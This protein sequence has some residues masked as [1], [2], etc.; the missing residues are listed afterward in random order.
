MGQSQERLA[1]EA[2][3]LIAKLYEVER[4]VAELDAFERL[5]IRQAKA[6]PLASALH[7]W[8]TTQRQKVPPGS[9]IAKAIDYSLG[10]WQPLTRCIADGDLPIEN[11]WVENQIRRDRAGPQELAVRRVTS[12][13]QARGRRDEPGA[14]GP[15]ERARPARLSEG[16]DGTPADASRKPHRRAAAA[17]L[18]ARHRLIRSAR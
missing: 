8:L 6:K 15:S 1:G 3:G 9:A 4:D 18:E 5:R 11:N 7:L 10:R 2:L 13:R 14:L 17:S 16:R 12:L